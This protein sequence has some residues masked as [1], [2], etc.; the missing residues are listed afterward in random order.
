MRVINVLDLGRVT[1]IL[2][3]FHGHAEITSPEGKVIKL[4]QMPSSEET[5]PPAWRVHIGVEL[6][7]RHRFW[8]MP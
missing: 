5:A 8:Y 3:W 7:S 4:M 2:L 6:N 1:T